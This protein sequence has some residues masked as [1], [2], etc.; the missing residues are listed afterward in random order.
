MRVGIDLVSVES[1][2]EAIRLHAERYLERI[3]TENELRDCQA[4]QGL[5]PLRLAARFA[6]KEATLKVLRPAD[7]AVPW[8]AIE[9]LRDPAGWVELKLTGSAAALATASGL[10]D[11][12]V[13]LTHESGFASAVVIA[14]YP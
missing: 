6:A 12:S 8:N 13:S 7:E 3:Y 2:Q 10:S 4:L 11:F 1:V 14:T 9:V 5:D